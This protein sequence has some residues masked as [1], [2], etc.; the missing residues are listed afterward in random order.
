[1]VFGKDCEMNAHE[2]INDL[3]ILKFSVRIVA[4]AN[5]ESIQTVK[6]IDAIIDNATRYIKDNFQA[7]HWIKTAVRPPTKAD[8]WPGKGLFEGCV[9]VRTVDGL[10]DALPWQTVTEEPLRCPQWF[11]VPE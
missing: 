11:K 10:L 8:S 3:E 9:L 1:M 2:V 5:G 6:P 4:A 7:N